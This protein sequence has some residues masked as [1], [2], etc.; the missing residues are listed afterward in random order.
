MEYTQANLNLP[1]SN[2]TVELAKIFQT[3]KTQ[4]GLREEQK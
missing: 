3:V 1:K 4:K 2:K